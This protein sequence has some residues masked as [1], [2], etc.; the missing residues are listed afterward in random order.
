MEQNKNFTGDIYRPYPTFTIDIVRETT[1][2]HNRYSVFAIYNNSLNIPLFSPS[3]TR[4]LLTVRFF[5][6]VCSFLSTFSSPVILFI[7]WFCVSFPKNSSNDIHDALSVV[8][9]P[10]IH[11]SHHCLLAKVFE[12]FRDKCELYTSELC[13]CRFVYKC[14]IVCDL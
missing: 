3:V 6:S 9:F 10:S 4:I 5:L 1:I 8:N 2:T 13:E 12:D 7:H 14:R 11:A